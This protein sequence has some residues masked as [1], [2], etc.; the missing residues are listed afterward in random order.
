[1]T[2]RMECRKARVEAVLAPGARLWW[3]ALAGVSG[4]PLPDVNTPSEKI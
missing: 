3:K 1:M 4:D 2:V